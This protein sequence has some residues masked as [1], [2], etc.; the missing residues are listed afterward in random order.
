MS[1]VWK[2]MSR[3]V[4]YFLLSYVIWIN[5][6]NYMN[7]VFVVVWG[8][9]PSF[10]LETPCLYLLFVCVVPICLS[11]LHEFCF[12]C[13]SMFVLSVIE[14][15]QLGGIWS[16]TCWSM[17]DSTDIAVSSV[18]KALLIKTTCYNISQHTLKRN[19]S[20]VTDVTKPWTLYMLS[21]DI[22]E[23]GHVCYD[24]KI[25]QQQQEQEKQQP[26]ATTFHHQLLLFVVCHLFTEF[27]VGITIKIRRE[28]N[29]A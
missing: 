17:L 25:T 8:V 5:A 4:D 3:D 29:K 26:A 7:C 15:V 9:K 1:E 11:H 13:F 18:T 27:P 28:L 14:P 24:N 2:L 10:I 16:V 21:G 20:S 19:T 6:L 12:F 22:G 23:R